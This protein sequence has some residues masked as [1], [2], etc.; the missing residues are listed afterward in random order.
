[1]HASGV[2]ALSLIANRLDA[3]QLR[4]IG[5]PLDAGVLSATGDLSAGAPLPTF[6]G[7]VTI[8]DGRISQFALSGGG[9]MHLAGDAVAL[10]RVVGAL[11]STYARVDG[12]IGSLSSGSPAYELGA[13][14]PAARI[15]TALHDFGLSNYLT[16]GT[17]NAQLHIGGRSVRPSISGTIGV[18]AG[19]VNGLPFIDGHASLAADPQG[20]AMRGGSVLVGTTAARFTAV[21]RPNEKVVAVDAPRADLSDFNNFFDTGDTLDGNGSVK[22]SAA[23][24]GSAIKTGGDI[25]VRG[26]RYRN[27]PIGDTRAAWSS[28]S[29]VIAGALA[30]GGSEG[31]LR[32][33]G[34]VGLTPGGQWQQTLARSRFDLAGDVDDLDLSLWMPALGMQNVPITGR[35][36]GDANLHGRFPQIDV[37]GNARI[38][39]GT[40]G[41]LT[42]D[43]AQLAVHAAHR[44][45]VIDRAEMAT[46]ELTASAAG[47]L[48]LGPNDPL[49]VQVHAATENLAQL[50]YT[51]SRVKVPVTGSFES[52]LKI[53][54]TYKAPTFLAGFDATDVHAYGIPIVSLFGELHLHGRTLVLSDAGATFQRGQATLAGSLPLQLAP[55]RLAAPDEPINFD[56]DVV[57]LDPA[58]FDELLGYN[59]RL[60]GAINGH[61]GLSGTVREPQILGHASLAGGS[62]V[63]DLQRVPITRVNAALAFNHTSASVERAFAQLGAGTVQGSGNVTFPGGLNG[64]EIALAFKGKA[65]GAQLDMPAYGSGTIEAQLTLVKQPKSKALLAGRVALSNATLPFATFVKAAAQSGALSGP[66]A[67]PLAFD[68]DATAGKNVR[69]RG[70]GYGAGLDIGATGSVRLGGTLTAPTLDGGFDSTG[71]TLT[72]FDR[73]FRVQQ[74]AVRFNA[75][76]GVL[77]T[78]NAVATT[79]IVNPDPDR[80][81]NPYGSADVT[82]KVDGPIA[83]LKIGLTSNP[84]GYTQDQILALIA[85]FGGFIGGIGYSAQ[86]TLARQQPSGITPLGAVSPIP[87][88]SLQQ[89]SS[90]TVGQEAFNILNAQFTAGLLAPVESTLG[91]GLGLSSVNL[92]LGYYGNVGVSASRLLGKSVSAVYA[93]TFGIPQVQS[94]GLQVQATPVTT[95]VLNF[96]YQSGPTKLLQQPS[97]PVGYSVGYLLGQPLI[98]NSGFSLTVQHN[99]W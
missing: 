52:G 98:G 93:V 97:S 96:F 56:L 95:A 13:G 30:V 78:I 47:S 37:R 63:S 9:D 17:F 75:A 21:V 7:G 74:G 25:D 40:L 64:G 60:G 50:V 51:F 83:G 73:A 6:D 33:Q 45:I 12:S 19:D 5:L 62:Y 24:R 65:Q 61:V 53:G 49:E 20:V 82:I 11:G 70:S 44:R 23:S 35:A 29:N 31:R 3:A 4:G 10:R 76:D 48:G 91:Q 46:P 79:S 59:T 42:L 28:A 43:S 22:F 92:T 99:F 57:D 36:S 1:R 27:L 67:L 41:P 84:P 34:S 39:R 80:A 69:V 14:V 87:N 71:G 18:P 86:S 68:L 54:G 77:P 16:D 2:G 55:L 89:R 85:P 90:I 88:V 58:I 38:T 81:R 15:A 26:F 8:G 94:F 72:Y 66:A 32:A